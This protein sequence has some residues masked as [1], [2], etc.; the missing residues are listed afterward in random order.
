M[1]AMLSPDDPEEMML[2]V[3]MADVL[4]LMRQDFAA[5]TRTMPL[6]PALHRLLLYVQRR[7][8]ARQVELAEWLDVT[9]V[10]V[11]RMI[12]RLERQNL[13]RRENHPADR[14]A[15]CVYIGEGATELLG[16]L[17]A[18]ANETRERA[19]HGL[20]GQQRKELVAALQR[21][22][23]NLSASSTRAVAPE[24]GAA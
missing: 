2:G 24:A 15:T 14:R 7:P 9:P 20:S 10:T 13:V 4:R 23:I 18:K 11:G 19:V 21:V 17:T 8:G 1:N 22:R 3:L 5:R 6:P 12:D 16:Q